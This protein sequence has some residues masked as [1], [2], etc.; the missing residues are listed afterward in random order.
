MMAH[1]RSFS[2]WLM[3]LWWM[4]GWT[5][6]LFSMWFFA[7][8]QP[9]VVVKS[10]FELSN[11]T[12]QFTVHSYKPILANT[13]CG[14]PTIA[15]IVFED[16]ELRH[17]AQVRDNSTG[18]GTGDSRIRR[19]VTTGSIPSSLPKGVE[20]AVYKKIVYPC[21]GLRYEVKTAEHSFLNLAR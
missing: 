11:N 8:F 7:I 9:T 16:P 6:V 15:I 12:F 13:L 17:V 2:F 19:W 21:L 18:Y 20:I 10:Q 5:I 1:I 14:K 4:I 3:S